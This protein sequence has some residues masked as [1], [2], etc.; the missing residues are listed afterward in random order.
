V[1]KTIEPG[2]R[3]VI[4][5]APGWLHIRDRHPYL[6]VPPEAILEVVSHPHACIAG[7]EPNEEWSYR[8]GLG[9]TAWIKVVVHY[10]EG[11]GLVITAFPRRSFP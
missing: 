8:R 4:L 5:D 7:R 1:W 2:G 6:A 11:S 10:E 9:P 3:R